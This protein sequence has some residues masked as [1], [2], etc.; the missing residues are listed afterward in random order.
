MQRITSKLCICN[1]Q[2]VIDVVDDD[3]T[4]NDDDD[5]VDYDADEL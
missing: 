2:D 3:N 5:D 1:E 4:D